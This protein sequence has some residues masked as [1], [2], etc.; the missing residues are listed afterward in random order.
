MQDMNYYWK[1]ISKKKLFK[2][3]KNTYTHIFRGLVTQLCDL[4]C[5]SSRQFAKR[6][7]RT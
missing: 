2:I 5:H 1:L 4:V 6:F 3:L 7:H